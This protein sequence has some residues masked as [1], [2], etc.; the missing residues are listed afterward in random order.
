MKQLLLLLLLG[1]SLFGNQLYVEKHFL[2]GTR[3]HPKVNPGLM[4]IIS[5]AESSGKAN[6]IAFLAEPEK[7]EPAN[8]L[9]SHYGI[10]YKVSAYDAKRYSFS[11]WPSYDQARGVFAILRN[12]K[13]KS[14]DIGLVQVNSLNAQRNGWDEIKLLTDLSYNIDKGAI[15]LSDCISANSTPERY[16]ECYNKGTHKEYS[17]S[18][19]QRI[20]ALLKR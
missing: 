11:V 20:F 2:D 18:Y 17:Y 14:Y 10:S 13:I 1:L 9:L 5:L 16:I 7:A 6:T 19:Y 3:N 8:R 15:I 12:A 4:K